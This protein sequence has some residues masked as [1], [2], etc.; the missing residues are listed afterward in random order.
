VHA[1]FRGFRRFVAR[2][3][4]AEH[5]IKPFAKWRKKSVKALQRKT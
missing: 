3:K 5:S 4:L 2:K 1:V